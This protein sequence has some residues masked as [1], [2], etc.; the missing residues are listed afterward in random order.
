MRLK[1]GRQRKVSVGASR[2]KPRGFSSTL[3][4]PNFQH[5]LNFSSLFAGN[6]FAEFRRGGEKVKSDDLRN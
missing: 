2:Q 6:E 5:L 1:R 4:I 3:K